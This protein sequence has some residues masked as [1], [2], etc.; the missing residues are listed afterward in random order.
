[1]LPAIF[2]VAGLL[3]YSMSFAAAFAIPKLLIFALGLIP[4]AVYVVRG[5]SVNLRRSLLTPA[6]PLL[7][8]MLVSSFFAAEP[9]VAIVGRHNSFALGLLGVA[10]ALAYHIAAASVSQPLWGYEF[11]AA[12]NTRGLRLIAA[13]GAILG[14]HALAQSAGIDAGQAATIHGHR[15]IASIGSP[16]DLGLILAMLLPLAAEI[17]PVY[18]GAV[19]LGLASTG[20]RGA[21]IAAGVGMLVYLLRKKE[22][23]LRA[24]VL[25]GV[26]A[27]GV[28]V[29]ATFNTRPW[30][31]SDR[32]R[33]EIWKIA[34]KVIKDRQIIGHGP[35][36]FDRS[37]RLYKTADFV[38]NV[39]TDRNIQADA[40]NDILQAAAT[41]GGL[42]LGAY[43]ILVV[44]ALSCLVWRTP[45]LGDSSPIHDAGLGSIVALLVNVKI[46]PVPLEA[47]VVA[48]VIL[49]YLSTRESDEQPL[50]QPARRAVAC[51]AGLAVGL[52]MVLAAADK[53]AGRVDLASL[54]LASKINPFEVEYK[55]RL[56]NAGIGELNK[57][58]DPL[59]RGQIVL[60]MREHAL[61]GVSLRPNNATAWYV[62]G[63]E[64][65]VEY[66]LGL[67]ERS[68]FPY[69]ERARQFDP[70]FGPIRMAIAQA[71]G[72]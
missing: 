13:A 27:A 62:A 25:L 34:L 55:S 68:P 70:L 16:T 64:A 17:S 3:A 19:A 28:A 36:S 37:F 47:L 71:R 42:G 33:V 54:E 45:W 53:A 21:W 38:M 65:T 72:L 1:M 11:G 8:V 20:S 31:Q 46:N 4:F 26:L 30:S 41:L 51:L 39:H 40:H 58:R 63:V 56:I 10:I 44:A 5:G 12:W 14:V 49:G 67:R 7:A 43:L 61:R 52:V 32:E 9:W 59:R 35:D 6:L 22:S 29:A 2:A 69:Y 60:A 24:L 57:T 15:A 48:G 23:R 50:S 66:E 18:G